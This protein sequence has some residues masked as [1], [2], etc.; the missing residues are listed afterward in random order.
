[1]SVQGQAL[2][3]YGE[4]VAAAHLIASGMT[5][6]DRNWRCPEGEIDIVARDGD[7]LVVCEVKTRR[8]NGFGGPLEAITPVKAE[9]LRRLAVRWMEQRG[10]RPT[11][12][13]IDAVGILRRERG[14]A[15]VDH[16]RGAV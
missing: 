8:G 10:V 7:V 1:V 13:R 14:P 2:G 9:R 15:E 4:R 16:L 5:I 12:I 11:E 3:E 6:L